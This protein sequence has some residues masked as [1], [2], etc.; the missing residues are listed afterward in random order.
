MKNVWSRLDSYSLEKVLYLFLYKHLRWRQI[1]DKVPCWNRIYSLL[2]GNSNHSWEGPPSALQRERR[3]L[4]CG[5]EECVAQDKSGSRDIL[6]DCCE[7]PKTHLLGIEFLMTSNENGA[8]KVFLSCVS[9]IFRSPTETLRRRGR[10]VKAGLME[11]NGGVWIRKG[12]HISLC[13]I[14][15]YGC[16][17]R[18][19]AVRYAVS[20]PNTRKCVSTTRMSKLKKRKYQQM[21]WEDVFIGVLI[22]AGKVLRWAQ[23]WSQFG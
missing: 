22:P 8:V 6:R 23:H 12:N 18:S 14:K 10:P 21:R 1:F 5:D 9:P 2:N 16:L 15:H 19:R 13:F 4:N 3:N 17:M 11:I 7:I 20:L